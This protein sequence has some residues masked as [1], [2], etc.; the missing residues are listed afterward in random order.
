M[1]VI[2]E[3]N[4]Q[5][6][7]A[8]AGQKLFAHRLHKTVISGNRPLSP[9]LSFLLLPSGGMYSSQNISEVSPLYIPAM[10]A[11]TNKVSV[12]VTAVPPPHSS[13]FSHQEQLDHHGR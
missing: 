13:S 6:F 7:K 3:I 1:Y 9:G 4:G 8:E 5:Q 2:V 12:S 10:T 11:K